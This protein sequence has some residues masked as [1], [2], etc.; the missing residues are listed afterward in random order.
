MP[1]SS[2]PTPRPARRLGAERKEPVPRAGVTAPP[3]PAVRPVPPRKPAAPRVP[4]RAGRLPAW[5]DLGGNGTAAATRPPRTR[6]L[7]LVPS[8][9]TGVVLLVLAVLATLFVG[10]GYATRALL[11]EAQQLRRENL[12]LQLTNQRLRGAVDQMT[13]PGA[14]IERAR[15]LGLEEGIAYGPVVYVAR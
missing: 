9:R 4:A 5:S 3:R 2:R 12:T 1:A 10:H 14:V 13:G 6:A 8:L 11:A 7:D 15:A